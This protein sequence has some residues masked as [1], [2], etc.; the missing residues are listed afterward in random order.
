VY[1]IIYYI[2]KSLSIIISGDDIRFLSSGTTFDFT[3]VF[4]NWQPVFAF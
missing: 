1:F 3:G 2:P 4:K